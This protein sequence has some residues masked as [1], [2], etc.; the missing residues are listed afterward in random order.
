MVIH[1]CVSFFIYSFVCSLIQKIFSKGLCQALG[2]H[3]PSLS[4]RPT[5]TEPWANK[6]T[7]VY[8]NNLCTLLTFVCIL[9]HFQVLGDKIRNAIRAAH[10]CFIWG[11][12]DC[13]IFYLLLSLDSTL[14]QRLFDAASS[15]IFFNIW[16]IWLREAI[17]SLGEKLVRDTYWKWCVSPISRFPWYQSLGVG[18]IAYWHGPSSIGPLIWVPDWTGT[19]S[20][21]TLPKS[22]HL[23]CLSFSIYKMDLAK[24]VLPWANCWGKEKKH[25][26]RL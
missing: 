2:I 14:I 25:I 1:P 15:T 9:V 3:A 5:G 4:W 21:L 16:G 23:W 26:I 12:D 8:L 13:S 20:Y 22:S 17:C 24:L 10:F 19:W 11:T 18:I 7:T 6:M